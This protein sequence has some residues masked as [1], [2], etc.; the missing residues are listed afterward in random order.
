MWYWHGVRSHSRTGTR[1]FPRG[2]WWSA[3]RSRWRRGTPRPSGSKSLD[4][5]S[6]AQ[7]V[8]FRSAGSIFKNPPVDYAGRLVEVAGVKGARIGQAII[9]EKHGNFFVNLGGAT[10]T[11]VLA[12]IALARERVRTTSGIDLELEIRV[13]GDD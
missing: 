7:P 6:G 2:R 10:A 5:W 4:G 8:E 3:R 12:L 13:V 9:S 11:D 1:A